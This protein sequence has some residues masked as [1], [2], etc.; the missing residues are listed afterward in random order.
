MLVG[1]RQENTSALKNSK[2]WR[3]QPALWFLPP[4]STGWGLQSWQSF[5]FLPF[6]I[7]FS[8][9]FSRFPAHDPT[10]TQAHL[11]SSKIALLLQRYLSNNKKN[12]KS[13]L[14]T[15]VIVPNRQTNLFAKVVIKLQSTIYYCITYTTGELQSGCVQV[16]KNQNKKDL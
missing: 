5:C 6:K 8:L 12:S 1:M 13:R 10:T 9:I 4:D 16:S 7:Q 2:K 3:K 15:Y 11:C 14:P